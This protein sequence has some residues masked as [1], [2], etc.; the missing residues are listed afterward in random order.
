MPHLIVYIPLKHIDADLHLKSSALCSSV[1]L[2][3]NRQN[4]PTL[5]FS[6][7]N[8]NV[9][10]TLNPTFNFPGGGRYITQVKYD[11][12]PYSNLEFI[13]DIPVPDP[14]PDPVPVP[15]LDPMWDWNQIWNWN[16]IWD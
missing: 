9:A 10:L 8:L 13:F 4:N 7:P 2:K 1:N 15:D 14:G 16:R 6:E 12:D 11:S 3:K 5:N